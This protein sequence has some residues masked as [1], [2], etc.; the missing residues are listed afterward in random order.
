MERAQET[1]LRGVELD[2]DLQPWHLIAP[3]FP[4]QCG[5]VGDYTDR[6]ARAL[7]EAGQPV[8]VWCPGREAARTEREGIVVHRSMGGFTPRDL[9]WLSAALKA[10]PGPRRLLVQW[11]PHGYGYRSMNVGFCL[12][13]WNRSRRHGDRVEVMVHEPYLPFRRDNWRQSAAAVLHR[14]MSIILLQAARKVWVA[15]PDWERRLRRYK[16]GRR[17]AMV[18][19]PVFSN[20]PIVRDWERILTL[21]RKYVEPEGALI[22]HFGTYGPETSRFL[23]VL[24]PALLEDERVSVVLVGKDS[25]RFRQQFVRRRPG[26]PRLCATGLLDQVETSLHLSACD[27]WIQPYADGVSGRRSSTLA[28][29]SHGQAVVTTSGPATESVW[30]ASGAVALVPAGDWGAFLQQAREL[31]RD[32]DARR[33]LGEAARRLYLEHLDVSHTVRRLMDGEPAHRISATATHGRRT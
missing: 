30:A 5:G 32:G 33:R 11:V 10:W 12:W 15:I 25:D 9:R 2:V 29:I 26:L 27:L 18:W 1:G 28:V 3:E 17:L 21:R 8:Q 22:G 4:P 19:S 20:V 6:L 31:L 14:L 7:A 24:L 16:L 13:L 23:Q